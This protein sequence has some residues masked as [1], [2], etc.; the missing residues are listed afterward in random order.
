MTPSP[1]PYQAAAEEVMKALWDVIPL[2]KGK[3]EQ[4]SLDMYQEAQTL[5]KNQCFD[6]ARI[7]CETALRLARRT[8][9]SR[10][11]DSFQYTEGI[12]L[13][14]LGATYLHC[15][16]VH[17]AI[18]HFQKATAEFRNSNRHRCES[19]AWMAIGHGYDLLIGEKEKDGD[20]PLQDWERALSAFQRS[21]NSIEISRATDEATIRLKMQI[22]NRM[23]QIHRSFT[24][25]LARSDT[26]F[27]QTAS[28]AQE[29]V[30]SQSETTPPPEKQ[31]ESQEESD[32]PEANLK[33]VPI[34]A[35]VRAGLDRL[36][37]QRHLGFLS[38][39]ADLSRSVTHAIDIEGLSMVDEGIYPG[40]FVLV[41][42]QKELERSELGVFLITYDGE[43]TE[44]T[45]KHFYPEA[46]HT[47]LQPMNEAE[48]IVLIIPHQKDAPQ[49]IRQ[50]EQQGHVVRSY[51][52]AALQIV[53]K[54]H[55]L[56]RLFDRKRHRR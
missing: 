14:F 53:A 39:D 48:P 37:E 19:V 55:G 3:L 12:G 43:L 10:G 56:F 30:S 6:R 49:I 29:T 38:V 23:E 46:N 31:Q 7:C 34:V 45:L 40:D 32:P 17:T 18:E 35:I 25:S 54:A 21:L 2:D 24:E 51:I 28:R 8:R 5:C 52:N 33:Q 41:H 4:A 44:T 11:I 22:V 26:A 27:S 15:C 42:E 20:V 16:K 9:D 36:A 1:N 47:R 50:Y 13:A